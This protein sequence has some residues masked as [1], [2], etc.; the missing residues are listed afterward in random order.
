MC[1]PVIKIFL[2]LMLIW[3]AQGA[4][5]PKQSTYGM[6]FFSITIF[7]SNCSYL[8]SSLEIPTIISRSEWGAKPAKGTV[9]SL[10]EDS[11]SYVIIHHAASDSC[12]NRAICQAR[13]RSFQVK[14]TMIHTFLKLNLNNL[15]LW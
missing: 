7:F 13:I 12:T 14:L 1:V 8:L 10:S 4:S 3:R 6:N 2:L 5:L 11:A 15:N 9:L